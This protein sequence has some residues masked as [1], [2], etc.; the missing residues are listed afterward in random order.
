MALEVEW[1][2]WW[3]R[4]VCQWHDE[5]NSRLAVAHATSGGQ[6]QQA[7]RVSGIHT[8]D[9]RG[10][11]YPSAEGPGDHPTEG[12]IQADGRGRDATVGSTYPSEGAG[13]FIDAPR[14]CLDIGRA[15]HGVDESVEQLSAR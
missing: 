9:A 11:G 4:R 12:T 13:D 10:K 8:T 14:C 6:L 5:T 3:L 2:G 1:G 7:R 15:V